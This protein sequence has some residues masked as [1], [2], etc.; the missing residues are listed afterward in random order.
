[1]KEEMV[2]VEINSDFWT[3]STQDIVMSKIEELVC[4]IMGKRVMCGQE[5]INRFILWYPPAHS[6]SLGCA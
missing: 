2:K 5:V 3:V 1:L 4:L 6:H